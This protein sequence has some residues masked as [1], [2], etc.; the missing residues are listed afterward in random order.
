MTWYW[1]KYGDVLRLGRL[2]Q[3]LREVTAAYRLGDDL[4]SHLRAD[5]L[6]IE[7][8]SGPSARQRVWENFTLFTLRIVYPQHGGGTL[9]VENTCT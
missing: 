7:I 3:A 5:C 2:P 8:S 6:H 4:K 1:S 9:N